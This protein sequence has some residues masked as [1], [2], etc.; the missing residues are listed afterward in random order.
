M[1]MLS[2]FLLYG[3]KANGSPYRLTIWA[4]D[5]TE[6]RERAQAHAQSNRLIYY[7]VL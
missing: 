1:T 6:A 7:K 2:A 4:Y 3:E 5:I